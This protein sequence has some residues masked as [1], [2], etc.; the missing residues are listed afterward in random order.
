V[1]TDGLDPEVAVAVQQ[2]GAVQDGQ[3]AD[4]L[5]PAE[6]VRPQHEEVLDGQAFQ[7]WLGHVAHPLGFFPISY[8]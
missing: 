8:L 4:V 5:G 6:I 3:G 1:S 2:P 7:V